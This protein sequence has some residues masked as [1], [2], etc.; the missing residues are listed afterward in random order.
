MLRLLHLIIICVCDMSIKDAILVTF[1]LK[2]HV[3]VHHKTTANTGVDRPIMGSLVRSQTM[4]RNLMV[5]LR[6][7]VSC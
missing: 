5:F 4:C 7:V 3:G 6:V 2:N 1:L